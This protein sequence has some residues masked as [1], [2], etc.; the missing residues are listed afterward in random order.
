MKINTV[1]NLVFTKE[2]KK[3]LI[4][5]SK[6]AIDLLGAFAQHTITENADM[7]STY[8][9]EVLFSENDIATL[10]CLMDRMLE[11]CNYNPYD[12]R[13][14]NFAENIGVEFIG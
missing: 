4:N 5:T 7:V 3:A 8:T 11:I 6:I 2:D 1:Q 9:G 14:D 12:D 10:C 13:G